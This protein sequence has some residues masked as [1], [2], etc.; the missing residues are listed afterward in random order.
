MP[1]QENR[2]LLNKMYIDLYLL[3]IYSEVHPTNIY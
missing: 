3:K 2:N 1:N